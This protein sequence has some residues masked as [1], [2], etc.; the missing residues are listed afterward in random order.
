MWRTDN[1]LLVIDK[2]KARCIAIYIPPGV[3]TDELTPGVYEGIV[4]NHHGWHIEVVNG[5]G[6]MVEELPD[7]AYWA[8]LPVHPL[9][10]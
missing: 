2:A 9:R 6:V 5:R 7:G 1:P 10:S 8:P 3:Q 4:E